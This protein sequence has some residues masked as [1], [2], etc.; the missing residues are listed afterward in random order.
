MFNPILTCDGGEYEAGA[1]L[2][3]YTVG[4]DCIADTR[5]HWLGSVTTPTPAV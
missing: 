4:A 1:E 2:T 3:P 5:M